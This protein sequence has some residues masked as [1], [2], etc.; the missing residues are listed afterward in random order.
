MIS[1]ISTKQTLP[2]VFCLGLFAM[3]SPRVIDPELRWRFKTGE[4][5]AKHKVSPNTDPLSC[6][7]AAR[8]PADCRSSPVTPG[9]N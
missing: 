7:W 9:S 5:I 4:S 3:A 1:I 6:T 8:A 2:A